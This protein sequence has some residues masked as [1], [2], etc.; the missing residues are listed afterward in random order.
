MYW[1][2]FKKGFLLILNCDFMLNNKIFVQN[3]FNIFI[4]FIYIL[5]IYLS[6]IFNIFTNRSQYF[7]KDFLIFLF[8]MFLK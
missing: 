1:L 3:I 5:L 6:S 4:K 8:K 7:S 2:L